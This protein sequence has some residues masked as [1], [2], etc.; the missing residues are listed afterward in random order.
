M[1]GA[2]LDLSMR[3]WGNFDLG[4]DSTLAVRLQHPAGLLCL[5]NRYTDSDLSPTGLLLHVFYS[6]KQPRGVEGWK[7]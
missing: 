2:D 1:A 5:R 7:P 6:G 3:G 4:K